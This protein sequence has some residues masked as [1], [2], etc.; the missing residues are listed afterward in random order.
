MLYSQRTKVTEFA[1][2]SSLSR[3][4]CCC[5]SVL[6]RIAHKEKQDV[7]QHKGNKERERKNDDEVYRLTSVMLRL[8]LAQVVALIQSLENRRWLTHGGP[9]NSNFNDNRVKI[10]LHQSCCRDKERHFNALLQEKYDATQL[11]QLDN[12]IS[13]CLA[14]SSDQSILYIGFILM[15]MHGTLTHIVRAGKS[16]KIRLTATRGISLSLSFVAIV[17]A[18]KPVNHKKRCDAGIRF[19]RERRLIDTRALI[20]FIPREEFCGILLS[21]Y[22]FRQHFFCF[23]LDEA[24]VQS[25]SM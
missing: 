23:K 2:S 20:N 10:N 25:S 19:L 11:W 17:D 7:A 12:K 13:R 16:L 6:S 3:C 5:V 22:K 1:S 18:E 4:C 8:F 14:L 21:R 15:I 24:K 9:L